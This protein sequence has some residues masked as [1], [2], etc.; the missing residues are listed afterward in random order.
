MAKP[1]S[2]QILDTSID[3][4]TLE[5][6]LAAAQK[7]MLGGRAK[8]L[9][10]PYVEFIMRARRD[11]SIQAALMDATLRLPNG[12]ALNWAA[13]YL[14]GGRPGIIRLVSTLWQIVFQPKRI[15]TI[16][17]DRFDSSNFTW[18]L[19][20][21]TAI[22]KQ[23]V[24]LVGSPKRQ[25]INA[26]TAYLAS[27]I[28]GLQVAGS[29]TGHLNAAKEAELVAKLKASKPA[30]ILIGIGFPRQ[31]LLMQRLAPQ[32]E[33]GL[34]LGEGGSFDYEQFGGHIKRAPTWMRRSGLE[35]FWRLV[36]E[37][38]R[39]GRQ[40]VIPVFIWLVYLEGRKQH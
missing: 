33:G 12:V 25:S 39:L 2:Y 27:A 7:I 8:Y 11:P 18:S 6:G 24:F 9:V 32:L 36:R 20:K 1:K 22:Q 16:L 26:V 38:S 28:P 40:L 19:L 13:E 31:E 21:A 15:H 17:P 34:M 37:P 3:A 23:S 29:F 5:G 4:L 30:L 10:L 35:W 14:Y